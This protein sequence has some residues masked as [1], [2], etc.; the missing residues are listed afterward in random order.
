MAEARCYLAMGAVEL[1]HQGCLECTIAH[2]RAGT[3]VGQKRP[4]L[5]SK[6]T[7]FPHNGTILLGNPPA[8][9]SAKEPICQVLWRV[10]PCR[11]TLVWLCRR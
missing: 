5:L 6:S 1:Q 7:S 10:H 8:F 11:S 4:W 9:R 3:I 2:G